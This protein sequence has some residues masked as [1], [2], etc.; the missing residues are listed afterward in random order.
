MAILGSQNSVT[1]E[2]I[3]LKFDVDDYVSD[4]TSYAKFYKI[5]PDR[6]LLAIW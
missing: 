2:P 6:G 5:Q 1:T 3:D 4:L